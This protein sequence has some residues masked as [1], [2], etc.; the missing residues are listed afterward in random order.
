MTKSEFMIQ[1]VLSRASIS[2]SLDGYMAAIEAEK[3]WN[4]IIEKTENPFVFKNIPQ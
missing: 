2:E 4:V 3:A 1:Y